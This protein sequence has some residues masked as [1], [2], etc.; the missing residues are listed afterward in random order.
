MGYRIHL[1]ASDCVA[2]NACYEACIDQNDIDIKSGDAPF[3]KGLE[4]EP[5]SMTKASLSFC[6]H[7]RKAPCIASCPNG[8]IYRDAETG[9]IIYDDSR[10]SAC[11]ECVKACPFEAI[12][13]RSDGRIGKCDGCNERVKAGL[14]PACVQC[15]PTGCLRLE[16]V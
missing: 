2:C 16:E 12:H 5:R 7:C 1:Y 14:L 6:Q 9:F 4:Y 13:P 10:C 11:G 8:C 3:R 15:C